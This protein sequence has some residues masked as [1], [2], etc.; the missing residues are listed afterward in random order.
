MLQEAEE[1]QVLQEVE[2]LQVLQELKE[3]EELQVQQEQQ[4]EQELQEVEELQE[5]QELKEVEEQQTKLLVTLNREKLQQPLRS[6]QSEDS[7]HGLWISVKTEAQIAA[8]HEDK[9]A[10]ARTHS[11]VVLL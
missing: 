7:A 8:Q 5:Q 9:A 11:G 3:V 1:L 10:Q 4:E 6:D 2:E